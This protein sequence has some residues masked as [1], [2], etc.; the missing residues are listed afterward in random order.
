[1]AP[2]TVDC[3]N[4][5]TIAVSPRAVV[6]PLR[7][8]IQTV[9]SSVMFNRE[10][11]LGSAASSSNRSRTKDRSK[12]CAR[13]R[14]LASASLNRSCATGCSSYLDRARLVPDR[15]AAAARVVRRVPKRPVPGSRL[16][17]ETGLSRV[18]V[19]IVLMHVSTN[20]VYHRRLIE[21]DTVLSEFKFALHD[22]D[23][24]PFW[25]G[26]NCRTCTSR[27]SAMSLGTR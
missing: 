16:S 21:R 11:E 25:R 2:S 26:R 13:A 9:D 22:H 7:R 10:R 1:M 23:A 5:P 27:R 14:S 19:P 24:R 20:R 17:N 8:L 18:G 3:P 12:R 6:T 4:H 15:R